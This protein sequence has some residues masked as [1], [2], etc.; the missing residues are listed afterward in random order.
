MFVFANI[1]NNTFSANK[2]E[3]ARII[4]QGNLY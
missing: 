2:T 3:K 4:C 1:L